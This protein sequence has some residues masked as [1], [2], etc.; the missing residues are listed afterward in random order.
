VELFPTTHSRQVQLAVKSLTDKVSGL[1]SLE[2]PE[3]WRSEPASYEYSLEGKGDEMIFQFTLLPPTAESQG[4]VAP[5][6]VSGDEVYT[7]EL[8]TI[9]YEH[10]PAQTVLLPA[11][12]KV[13]RLDV[14][15]AGQHIGYVMGAGDEIPENLEAIGYTVHSLE[16]QDLTR[17]MLRNMDAIVLGIR[18]YNVLDDLPFKTDVL[19]EYVREGGTMVVQYN[20]SGRGPR[21][22]S[23]LAPYPIRLSRDRVSDETAPV[24]I[25]EPEHPLLNF[26]NRVEVQDFDGWVQERGLYF[27]DKWD[28]AFTPLFAMNDPGETP[29]KGSLLAAPYGDGYYIYTGLSFF[30]EL[31]AGVPGAFK[32]LSNML[33]IG[34]AP[35]KSDREVKG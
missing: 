26:P 10:I 4:F 29:K 19:L 18:A 12:L 16:V 23:N 31:P 32:L 13:V 1:V 34:K 14:E 35:T 22:F 9:D 25:L 3:G 17:D 6:I 11:A 15:K 2:V 20:T 5:R 33:S 7:K 28:P 27:P 8:I 30:R 21:D 24:E